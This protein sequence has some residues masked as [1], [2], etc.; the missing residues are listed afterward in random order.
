MNLQHLFDLSKIEELFH[1]KSKH[2]QL[3]LFK[4]K[5]FFV[6]LRPLTV[7]ETK[8][9]IDLGKQID[10]LMIEN[11]ICS[12]CYVTSNKSKQFLIEQTPCFFVKNLA[13]KISSFSVLH[14]EKEFKSKILDS[15]NTCSTAQSV[16]EILISK[17]F[18]SLSPYDV[19]NLTQNKQIELL[20]KAEKITNSLLDLGGQNNANEILKSMR[21]ATV[22]GGNI[23]DP[24]AGDLPEFSNGR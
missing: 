18:P 8:Y 7:Q 19:E 1:A 9:I 23:T 13:T 6:V 11:L 21:G 14:E 20:G 5:D 4:N 22:I 24:G 16:I 2:G 12:L 17:A 10:E 15:R 3:F